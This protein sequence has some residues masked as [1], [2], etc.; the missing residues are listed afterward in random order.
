MSTKNWEAG[1]TSTL[2][3]ATVALP[4]WHY[5]AILTSN[6]AVV[7]IAAPS[8]AGSPNYEARYYTA[9]IRHYEVGSGFES[10]GDAMRSH[11]LRADMEG[12]WEEKFREVLDRH[13]C[14]ECEF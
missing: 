11:L 8:A 4:F 1:F 9:A 3:Q 2:V 6:S 12:T 14:E 7:R 13:F 10:M 5:E